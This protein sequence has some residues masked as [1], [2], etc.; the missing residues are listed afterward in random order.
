MRERI[1]LVLT[2]TL[3][4]VPSVACQKR[5]ESSASA[6]P[7]D[8]VDELATMEADLARTAAELGSLGIV[9]AQ[10]EAEEE[11]PIGASKRGESSTKVR[12]RAK[13]DVDNGGSSEPSKP[14]SDPKP[15]SK[16]KPGS[17]PDA[18]ADD[19]ARTTTKPTTPTTTP[20][21]PIQPNQ[22][23][24]PTGEP[25]SVSAEACGRICSLADLSCDLSGRI[26]GLAARHVG[27]ARYED[28][29]WNAER[30]CEAATDACSD[31]DDGS[32]AAEE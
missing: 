31:C 25:Q 12:D 8:A 30:Q 15:G 9:I 19:D 20:P 21:E 29:C 18:T 3:T 24:Q 26:C 22:P 5:A 2:L 16:L 10:R 23:S 13:D 28:S 4:L 14:S 6:M 27:D 11:V 1:A 32:C 7:N 17:E